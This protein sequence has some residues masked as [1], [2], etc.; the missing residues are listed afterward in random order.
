MFTRP[1][2]LTLF[3][4]VLGPVL[5]AAAEPLQLV[6]QGK[7]PYS[8]YYSPAA[9]ASVK[10]AAT[11]LQAYIVKASGAK[12]PIVT[13]F[14]ATQVIALGGNP[15]LA[16]NGLNLETITA[17]IPRNA[18]WVT[19]QFIEVSQTAVAAFADPQAVSR[20]IQLLHSQRL[21]K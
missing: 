20:A 7:S 19:V 6:Q 11:D 18:R 10:E 21:S 4:L 9:P 1:L 8:I 5:M 3:S 2:L 14:P 13:Q 15:Q 17:A 12:L 16:A